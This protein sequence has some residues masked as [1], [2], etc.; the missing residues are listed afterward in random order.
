MANVNAY[1]FP[2]LIRIVQIPNTGKAKRFFQYVLPAGATPPHR[3]DKGS[4][5]WAQ[6][7]KGDVL[8]SYNISFNANHTQN[9][10]CLLHK[11][12]IIYN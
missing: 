9:A 10:M 5:S 6:Y 4:E 1:R 2:M 3:Q 11:T 8:L 12:I 7:Q